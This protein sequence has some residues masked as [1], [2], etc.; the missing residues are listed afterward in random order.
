MRPALLPPWA[1]PRL[2]IRPRA[3]RPAALAGA[4]CVLS[5]LAGPGWAQATFRSPFPRDRQLEQSVQAA[6]T[7]RHMA[8]VQIAQLQRD[9]R[10]QEVALLYRK[11]QAASPRDPG[12]KA[13]YAF[14]HTSAFLHTG[15]ESWTAAQE[16]T[17]T[18]LS[19][20]Q[21]RADADRLRAESLREA[22]GAA[23]VWVMAALHHLEVGQYDR[24]VEQARQA[25]ALDPAW[26]YG[27]YVLGKSLVAQHNGVADPARR[28]SLVRTALK[29]L[30][31]AERMNPD[32]AQWDLYM[33]YVHAYSALDR[34]KDALPYMDKILAR[35]RARKDPAGKIKMLVA[36]REDLVRQSQTP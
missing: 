28:Q 20:N 12:L 33:S 29:E 16:E 6:S 36:W 34:H 8:F 10:A 19:Q 24:A 27:H 14:A 30:Q 13:L 7:K 21:E 11:L 17:V 4:L 25:V 31:T 18:F 22:P 35:A 3:N 32:L 15:F 2:R 1:A 26:S 5:L 23:E 9:G